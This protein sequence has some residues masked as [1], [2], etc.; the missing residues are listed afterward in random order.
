[1]VELKTSVDKKLFLSGGKM[2]GDIDMSLWRIKNIPAPIY[3]YDAISKAVLEQTYLVD[4]KKVLDYRKSLS[5]T[6][7]W[8]YYK[9]YVTSIYH[10]DRVS[11]NIE[12][13]FD[14][15]I[16]TVSKAVDQDLEENDA[17]QSTL[18]FQPTT[19]TKSE[20]VGYR[21]FLK[22]D[23]GQEMVSD[24]NLNDVT[25]DKDIAKIFIV[26]RIKVCDVNT[27]RVRNGLFGH[28]DR[29]FDKF[30]G[31]S[32]N[33]D[34]FVSGTTNNYIV[35]SSNPI[36]TKQPIAPYKTK[37]NAGETNKWICLSI[38]WDNYTTPAAGA[39]K[40][41]CNGQKLADF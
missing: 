21:F 10:F 8:E 30:V 36:Q 1:M 37:A 16:T 7:M 11:N 38:N 3:D 12:L 34:L 6:L 29:S 5:E 13:V 23:G 24:M 2:E 25:G 4:Y 28:N 15:T 35:I 31:F 40:A 22:F 32:P 9:K 26:H 27:Y 14:T 19:C 41:F 20:N 33:S 18:S 17:I 39:S